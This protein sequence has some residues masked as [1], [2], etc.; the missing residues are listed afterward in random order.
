MQ[1]E[2]RVRT[3]TSYLVIAGLLFG[4]GVLCAGAL[5]WLRDV[6]LA[7]PCVAGVALPF[8]YWFGSAAYRVGGGRHLIRFYADR[9]ELPDARRRR[10]IVMPR[11]R[12]VVTTEQVRVRV[13]LVGEVTRGVVVKFRANGTT[14]ALSTLV[15]EDRADEPA[16]LADIARIAA[17]QPAIGRAVL[18]APTPRTAYDDRIDREL[19]GLD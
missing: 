11:D 6:D 14:R 3:P 7:F 1:A 9:V 5:I 4:I 10:P 17:G 2:Y 16:L 19:A 15:L 8:A 18:D 13:R 12:L